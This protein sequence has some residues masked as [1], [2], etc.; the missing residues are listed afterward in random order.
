MS[1]GR[2]SGGHLCSCEK[3]HS[4]EWSYVC[5]H[6]LLA[7]VELCMRALATS[8][9][10]P[11]ACIWSFMH[12]CACPSLAQ[13]NF[14]QATAW[15]FGTSPIEYGG[16]IVKIYSPKSSIKRSF[17]MFL[18]YSFLKEYTPSRVESRPHIFYF[19]RLSS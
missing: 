19:S 10:A 3:F 6:P 18:M 4:R 9:Q 15:W 16:M 2:L 8:T 17:L 12:T 11:S 13:P 14:E 7:Q 1:G 5:K